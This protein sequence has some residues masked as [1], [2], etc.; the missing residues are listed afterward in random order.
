MRATLSPSFTSSKMKSMFFLISDCAENFTKYFLDKNEKII[1]V[2]M[3]DISTRFT[4]D[5]IA[6]AAFG[7]QCDSLNDKNNEFY[8]MGKEATDFS[9]FWKNM[10]F[11][12][13]VFLPKLASVCILLY[14]H[15]LHV[16]YY[17]ITLFFIFIRF[18]VSK[19]LARTLATFLLI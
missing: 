2:N 19:C 12:L 1:T 11:L 5:V 9:G 16:F 15:F 18:V 3:K 8:I 17:Y 10:R 6:T 14:V 4:N 13:T 7:I